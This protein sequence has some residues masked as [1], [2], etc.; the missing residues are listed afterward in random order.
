M[1]AT[2]TGAVTTGAVAAAAE[3]GDA[4][5]A[6]AP[7]HFFSG[8]TSGK[9]GATTGVTLDAGLG[10][11]PPIA[12]FGPIP[13]IAGFG[14]PPPGVVLDGGGFGK[15]LG[16]DEVVLD[17]LGIVTAL[18]A[19]ATGLGITIGTLEAAADEAAEGFFIIIGFDIAIGIST[20]GAGGA[21]GGGG[22][23]AVVVTFA[24]TGLAGLG[25]ELEGV[26]G[27]AVV[28]TTAVLPLALA[29]PLAVL[30]GVVE[31]SR[32]LVG[33]KGVNL[34]VAPAAVAAAAVVLGGIVAGVATRTLGTLVLT[35]NGREGVAGGSL[36]LTLTEG[37]DGDAGG[38]GTVVRDTT[39]KTSDALL[40]LREPITLAATLFDSTGTFSDALLTRRDSTALATLTLEGTTSDAPLMRRD[41]IALAK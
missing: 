21:G 14:K 20:G 5:V 27:V 15:T 34:F 9:G 12:G 3:I 29:L 10:P 32:G 33:L 11:T 35:V 19:A 22:A 37:R 38:G 28:A 6:F 31:G 18:D 7:P 41:D 23:A 1:A 30:E 13:P 24:C 2:G 8:A 26:E 4:A 25:R 16:D 17:G 39:G 36:A 40:T